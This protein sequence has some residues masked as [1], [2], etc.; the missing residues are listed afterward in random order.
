MPFKG[1]PHTEKG[2]KC[3]EVLLKMQPGRGWWWVWGEIYCPQGKGCVILLQPVISALGPV[4][5]DTQLM[6]SSSWYLYGGRGQGTVL[7]GSF[8][9][10]APDNGE[11]LQ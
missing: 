9:S 3:T 10:S 8:K 4:P 11:R 2:G 6:Q 7:Y 1:L 5:A